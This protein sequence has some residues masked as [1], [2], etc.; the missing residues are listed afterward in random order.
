MPKKSTS[1]N[2]YNSFQFA[3]D[4]LEQRSQVDVAYTDLSKTFNKLQNRFRESLH[5]QFSP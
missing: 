5:C 2:F 4:A 3:K 1:T